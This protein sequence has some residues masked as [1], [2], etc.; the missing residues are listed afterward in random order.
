MLQFV[1]PVSTMQSGIRMAT[2]MIASIVMRITT[3]QLRHIV[4]VTETSLH[5]FE[6]SGIP[7]ISSH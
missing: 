1:S 6:Y 7:N 2:P 5:S 3:R 4:V